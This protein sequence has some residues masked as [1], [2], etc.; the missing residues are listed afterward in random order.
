[1][2]AAGGLDLLVDALA[3]LLGEVADLHERVDEEA[4][5]QLGRQA[6][7]AGVGRIDQPHILQVGHDV[8]DRSRG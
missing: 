8:A 4:Q 2:G 1:L 3:L 5:A 6:S 7:G